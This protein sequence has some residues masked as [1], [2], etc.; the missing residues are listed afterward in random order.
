MTKWL[1]FSLLLL[2]ALPAYAQSSSYSTVRERLA[3]GDAAMGAL[4]YQE[5][6]DAYEGAVAI[7]PKLPDALFRVGN[8]ASL[9]GDTARATSAWEQAL[10]LTRDPALKAVLRAR[11]EGL[12]AKPAASPVVG[13]VPAPPPPEAPAPPPAPVPPVAPSAPRPPAVPAP[14][15][16]PAASA[17]PAPPAVPAAPVP[18]TAPAPPAAPVPPSAPTSGTVSAVAEVQKPVLSDTARADYEAGVAAINNRQFPEA[19]RKLNLALRAAPSFASGY[20]ARGSALI[21]L[22][23][24]SEALADYQYALKLEPARVTPYYGIGEANRALGKK[25]EAREAFKRL[26]DSNSPDVHPTVRADAEKKLKAL[27]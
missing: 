21:G 16:I 4:N 3:V 12:A 23:R 19:L 27:E 18:P 24:Y 14:P 20:V 25:D 26:V 6:L 13:V 11:L 2:C 7:E 5:A 22:R 9:L 17:A 10:E 15:A 8:A 1:S